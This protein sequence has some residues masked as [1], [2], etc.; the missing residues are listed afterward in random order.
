MFYVRDKNTYNRI[1]EKEKR[2]RYCLYL[3]RVKIE[4]IFFDEN[5]S[6][7]QSDLEMLRR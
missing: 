5:N 2:E 1:D 4:I 7:P 3:W 6:L